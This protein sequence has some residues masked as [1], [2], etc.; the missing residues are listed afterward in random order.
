MMRTSTRMLFSL[1]I[2][3]EAAH[4]AVLENSK[5][6]DSVR[7]VTNHCDE[8]AP[9]SVELKVDG[10]AALVIRGSLGTQVLVAQSPSRG[11]RARKRWFAGVS[12]HRFERGSAVQQW[13]VDERSGALRSA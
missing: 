3:A 2:T 4:G 8:G 11:R 7:S 10:D 1:P 5:Q 13:T 12:L 6:V 9:R